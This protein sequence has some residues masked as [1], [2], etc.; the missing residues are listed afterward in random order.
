M[1]SHA[2]ITRLRFIDF[3][4]DQYGTINRSAIMDYFGLSVAQASIDLN[5][6]LTHAPLNM[7]YDKTNKVYRKTEEFKRMFP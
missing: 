5:M 1:L 6:Y 7:V 3:L 2:H 4:L